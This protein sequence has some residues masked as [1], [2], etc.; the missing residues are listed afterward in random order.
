MDETILALSVPRDHGNFSVKKVENIRDEL[1]PKS[2]FSS[3]LLDEA[4]GKSKSLDDRNLYVLTMKGV[5]CGLAYI[6][7]GE[8]LKFAL[9]DHF[10]DQGITDTYLR[11]II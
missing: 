6:S 10:R 1:F 5:V 9:K 7:N 4:F 3:S 8:L 11:S 2:S